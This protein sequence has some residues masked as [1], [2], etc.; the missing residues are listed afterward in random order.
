[1]TNLGLLGAVSVGKTTILRLFVKYLKTKRISEVKG[2]KA[3]TVVKTDFSGEAVLDPEKGIKET[4]TIHPNRVVFRENDTKR[5]HTIFAPGG[6]RGRA[7][8]RMGVITISRISKK[9]IAVFDCSRPV[10]E[11]F[12]FF[13]DVRFFPKEI[14]VCF[15]KFDLIKEKDREK[16]I[17]KMKSAIIEYF[18]K[19]KIVIKK[20]YNVCAENIKGMESFNDEVAEM[21]LNIAA[22]S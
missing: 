14:N 4:K 5:N 15:N 16:T 3:C 10:K 7:V 17:K 8:V 1:M 18:G 21:L 22:N 9:I 6:D 13:R 11:Q 2:G 19:R 20:F 12:E